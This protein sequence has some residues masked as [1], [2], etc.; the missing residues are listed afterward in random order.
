MSKFNFW[1]IFDFKRNA[2]ASN[3]LEALDQV[4]AI[5]EFDT[6]GVIQTANHNFLTTL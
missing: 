2:E 4:Q 5:I 6:A 1:S 3:K